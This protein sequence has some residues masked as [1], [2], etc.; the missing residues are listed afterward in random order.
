MGWYPFTL[1]MIC[2]GRLEMKIIFGSHFFR[3]FVWSKNV[4]RFK[5]LLWL[6]S[7]LSFDIAMDALNDFC[8]PVEEKTTFSNL[9]M[10]IKYEVCDRCC[11]F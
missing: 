1:R 9:H 8:Q 7:C 2:K 10:E 6:C 11:W 5:R 3:K 4:L